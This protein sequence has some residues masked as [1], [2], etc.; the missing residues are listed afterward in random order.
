MTNMV[1]LYTSMRRAKTN[2]L[3]DMANFGDFT[4]RSPKM[5]VVLEHS[6]NGPVESQA[7]VSTSK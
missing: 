1:T 6:P 2:S 4:F 3:M 7:Q 5:E